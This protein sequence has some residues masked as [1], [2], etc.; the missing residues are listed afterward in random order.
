MR[1]VVPGSGS[2][3]WSWVA[4]IER[5]E[6]PCPAG[7]GA[8]P[9]PHALAPGFGEAGCLPCPARTGQDTPLAPGRRFGRPFPRPR[10]RRPSISPASTPPTPV[11]SFRFHHLAGPPPSPTCGASSKS[12]SQGFDLRP[13]SLSPLRLRLRLPLRPSPS[14]HLRMV[15][16]NRTCAAINDA[17]TETDTSFFD[18][19]WDAH[20][21][22]WLV[23]GVCAIVVSVW[24]GSASERV[25]VLRPLAS[26]GGRRYFTGRH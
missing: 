18:G 12:V 23:A 7:A 1:C 13:P 5:G 20:E 10:P 24:G 9:G 8:A 11:H 16:T 3:L 26:S 15:L 14:A 2:E 17:V 22:G 21:I 19:R 25:G 6:G 4:L